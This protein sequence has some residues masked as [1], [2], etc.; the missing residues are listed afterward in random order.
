MQNIPQRLLTE[1][2]FHLLNIQGAN[3]SHLDMTA[4][5]QHQQ[6]LSQGLQGS[7]LAMS[8]TSSQQPTATPSASVSASF[9]NEESS[10]S[11]RER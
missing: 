8:G 11:N 6:L 3:L 4:A 5:Q 1:S 7:N 9:L 10:H 2:Y